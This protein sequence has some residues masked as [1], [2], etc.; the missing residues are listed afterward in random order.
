MHPSAHRLISHQFQAVR[1]LRRK[2]LDVTPAQLR[3][4]VD[5]AARLY[6]GHR[7]VEVE[8]CEI[9]GIPTDILRAKQSRQ[10]KPKEPIEQVKK[11]ETNL[12]P[13]IWVHGGG[14]AF[15]SARTHRAAGSHLALDLKRPVW[16][17]DYN[18]APEHPFPQ[19]LEQ[20]SGLITKAL[21][22]HGTCDLIGDSAG[23]NLALAVCLFRLERN[24]PLPR[25]LALL[26]PWLDLRIDSPSY[27]NNTSESS[28]FDKDDM[29]YYSSFY[30]AGHPAQ[31]PLVS[32]GIMDEKRLKCL[33]PIRLESTP[34]DYLHPDAV[35]FAERIKKAQGQLDWCEVPGTFHAWQLLP[36]LLAEAKKSIADLAQFIQAQ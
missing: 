28:L 14:F 27:S 31:D 33:P 18:L 6:P 23:G 7:D 12:L 30:L 15:G 24:L 25:S 4:A 11:T 34:T 5:A 3:T 20:L 1:L 21:S 35:A 13:A 9:A 22:Q 19:A 36:D 29:R 32:P 8:R 17:P 10:P 16:L 26:S 2:V